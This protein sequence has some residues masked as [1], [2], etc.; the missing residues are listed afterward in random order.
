MNFTKPELVLQTIRAGDSVEQIRGENRTKVLRAANGFPPFSKEEADRIGIKVNVNWGETQVIIAHAVAQLISAFM[1][2]REFFT[3]KLPLAPA[4][5]KSDWE[6]KITAAINKPMRESL[7]FFELGF[8]RWISVAM[9][10]VGAMCWTNKQKWLPRFVP[11][12]DLRIPTDTT[13]DFRN[14]EWFARRIPYTPIELAEAAFDK[15]PNNHWD[16][17]AI[18]KIL[19][20]YKDKNFTDAANNYNWFNHPEE[21]L[22]LWKQNAGFY[23]SDAVPTIA[24]YH[25]YYRDADK[26][27]RKKTRW[28]MKVVA[29]STTV[30]GGEDQKFLWESDKPVAKSWKEVIHCQYGDLSTEVPRKFHCVRGLGFAVFEPVFFHNLLLCRGAQ[31]VFDQFNPW[32]R[33]SDPSEKARVRVQEFGNYSIIHPSLTLV[34]A[35]ERHQIDARMFESMTG[36]FKQLAGE[37][38]ASYTQQSDTGTN[39]EQTAFETRVKLEQVNSLMGSIL[40]VAFKYESYAYHE[41]CR[42]FLLPNSDDE[43]VQ[44]FQKQMK[45]ARIDPRFMDID[46]WDVEPVTPLGHGNPT[47]ALTMAQAILSIV[48]MLPAESQPKAIHEYILAVTKDPDRAEDYV[49]L[50]HKPNQTDATREATGLFSTLM[51]GLEVKL[52]GS[53]LIEQIDVLMP[54]LSGMIVQFTRRNNMATQE[55]GVGLM[56]TANYINQAIGQLSQDQ[57]QKVR[58][59]EYTDTM[60]K[61]T[62]EIKA[63]IQRGDQAAKAQQQTADQAELQIKMQESQMKLQTLQATTQAKLEG[64]KAKTAQAIALKEQEFAAEQQRENARL[65]AEIQRLNAATASEIHLDNTKTRAEI[66]QD[67]AKAASQIENDKAKAEAAAENARKQSQANKSSTPVD[68]GG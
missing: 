29:D 52:W 34:P 49:P 18:A 54:L 21:M 55:E 16:K 42:R 14:L 43:D 33:T 61:L 4:D 20:Q 63:L 40:M 30:R 50:R 37:A 12:S 7:E 2:N 65:R 23:S 67:N 35:A 31:H 47:I 41:I 17:K 46:L 36:K 11:L 5:Y 1:G 48:G 64:D 25:F 68:G 19:D 39:K 22:N 53:H 3:V 10:G 59:K 28:Y 27:D 57:N 15:S 24:L 51:L 44:R 26:K 45:A 8:S 9:N 66:E 58:V 60:G 38:S 6:A 62:N 13:N 32:L 56:N